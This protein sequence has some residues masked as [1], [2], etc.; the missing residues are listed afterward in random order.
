VEDLTADVDTMRFLLRDRRKAL[1]LSQRAV[2][3]RMGSCQSAV[4]D[5]ECG[6]FRDLR[7][8]TLEKWA[9]ALGLRIRLGFEEDRSGD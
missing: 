7:V 3:L 8:D 6:R 2:S 1:G 9:R 4:S 5:L